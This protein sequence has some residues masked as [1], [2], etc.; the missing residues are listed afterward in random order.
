MK[1]SWWRR[2]LAKSDDARR[3]EPAWISPLRRYAP[4]VLVLCVAILIGLALAAAG[5]FS[6]VWV[7][8]AARLMLV[9]VYGALA[10]LAV[11][12][13]LEARQM[14]LDSDRERAATEALYGLSERLAVTLESIGEGVI[15]TDLDG[16]I[17]YVNPVAAHLTAWPVGRAMGLSVSEVV[18]LVRED[19]HKPLPDPVESVLA[20]GARVTVDVGAVLMTR[21]GREVPVSCRAAPILDND[22]WLIG[23]VLVLEDVSGLR[24]V[25][26]QRERLIRE[27]SE[28]NAKLE[29]E[30]AR[31]EEGRRAALSL[32]QDAQMAQAALKESEARLRT[33]FEGIDDALFVHDEEGRLL[34]CNPAAVTIVGGPRDELFKKRIGDLLGQEPG[35]RG[36]FLL[37]RGGGRIPVDIHRS[38]IRYNGRPA[39]L[40]VAR[41]ITELKKIEDELR[42][43]NFQL[44]ESNEALEEYARVASHDLQEPLRK[45]ENFAQILVEDFGPSLD[46]RARQ[47]LDIMVSSAQRMRR[48]IRDVLAFSRSG[49]TEKPF[50]PVDLKKTAEAALDNLSEYIR[51]KRGQV[52]V[53]PLPTIH[54]DPTQMLQLLQ[55][56][57]GNA[58]KFNN[59][60]APRVEI[61]ALD[62][63]DEWKICVRD[64]GI[65]MRPEDTRRIFA[66]FKRLHSQEE[67]EGTGIGLAI[68]RRIVTRHGGVI[69]VDSELNK[70]STF[71]FTLP[72]RATEGNNRQGGEP[73]N[74][75]QRREDKP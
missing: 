43:S 69:G 27:L 56:L 25:Q 73:E 29:Q 35:G 23:A 63:K 1:E 62:G 24:A 51:E 10:A 2:R 36:P 37:V 48:L 72:K 28:A 46:E 55:N 17:T 68:C 54:G 3:V 9:L 42:A 49:F 45:I 7:S 44:R 71:W 60:P 57:V 59:K 16:L 34:D 21:D 32:M 5:A 74:R 61:F 19:D 41:D 50:E 8:L 40:V 47:Y 20:R 15:A 64:N 66:P 70:G 31:R 12:L 33:L 38:S 11:Y 26:K 58:L 4:A 6:L 52:D 39:T 75:S 65:G 18:H 13:F 53:K 30:V 22:G 67:Y 14:E